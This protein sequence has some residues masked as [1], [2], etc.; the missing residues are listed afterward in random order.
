MSLDSRLFSH[1]Y[2]SYKARFDS[3]FVALL[4]HF[5]K[6]FAMLDNAKECERF[7]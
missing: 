6:H 3:S 2:L 4:M 1:S 7:Y 5:L